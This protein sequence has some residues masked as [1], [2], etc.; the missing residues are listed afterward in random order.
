LHNFLRPVCPKFDQFLY[1]LF[2]ELR[3]RVSISNCDIAFISPHSLLCR[4]GSSVGIATGYGLD[5]PGIESRWGRDFPHLSRWALARPTSCTMGPGSFRRVKSGQGL[6]LT[7]HHLLVQWSR[8]SR[9]IPLLPLWAVRPVQ[10]L[11][12]CTRVHFTFFNFTHYHVL[13]IRQGRPIKSFSFSPHFIYC[14]H[15][16]VLRK[17]FVSTISRP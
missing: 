16:V 11:S 4:P 3:L 6:T 8:K 7:P 13:V 12:A 9:A 15:R 5:G 2:S 17:K 1:P 10:S 14:N